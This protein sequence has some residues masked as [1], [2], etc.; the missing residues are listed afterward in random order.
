MTG[1]LI[2]GAMPIG[3]DLD[4]SSRLIP[5]IMSVPVVV[6]ETRNNFLNFCLRN[7]IDYVGTVLELNSS[8]SES[9][10]ACLNSVKESLSLGDDVLIVS[11][12]GYPNILDNAPWMVHEVSKSGFD[13]TVIPGPSISINAFAVS[14][15]KGNHDQFMFAGNIPSN[16]NE[17][18][19]YL[20]ELKDFKFPMVFVTIPFSEGSIDDLL[21]V[22]GDRDIAICIDIT[23][24]TEKVLRGRLSSIQDSLIKHR[25]FPYSHSLVNGAKQNIHSMY[26]EYTLVVSG[27]E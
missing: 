3:N 4:V 17:R 23:K 7:K 19:D 15:L 1:Q 26:S 11:N 21:S 6:C 16:K 10:N 25:Q 20:E 14:A 8:V 12:A 22:F 9:F 27:K 18:I 2:I 5:T 24:D 13:V